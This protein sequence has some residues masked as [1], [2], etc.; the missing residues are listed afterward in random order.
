VLEKIRRGDRDVSVSVPDTDRW[1]DH[2]PVLVDD[3]A[4]TARTMMG[5]ASH[6]LQAGLAKP[7]CVA[8]HPVFADNAYAELQALGVGQIVSCNTIAHASNA[9]DL[10]PALAV[11]VQAMIN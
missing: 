2:T 9:V 11:A 3:I 6:V 1:R 5:A 4:S 7:V 10:V 8:V